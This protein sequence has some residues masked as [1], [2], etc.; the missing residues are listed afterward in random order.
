MAAAERVLAE[1][2]RRGAGAALLAIV[3][4]LHAACRT[5]AEPAEAAVEASTMVL[6]V[7]AYSAAAPG[8]VAFA[9][10]AV[11]LAAEVARPEHT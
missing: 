4:L 6:T 5:L 9:A 10:Q 1:R 11:T 8:R 3:A 2:D 7:A